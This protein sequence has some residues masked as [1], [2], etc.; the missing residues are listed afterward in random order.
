MSVGNVSVLLSYFFCDQSFR[1]RKKS[2]LEDSAHLPSS[3]EPALPRVTCA[4]AA[5]KK[6]ST[7]AEQALAEA[8]RLKW[9]EEKRAQRSKWSGHKWRWHREKNLQSYH[10]R[11]AAKHRAHKPRKYLLVKRVANEEQI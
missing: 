6:A 7:V 9:R 8:Q 4:L 11:Q 10:A 2:Q 1:E 5:E 3:R